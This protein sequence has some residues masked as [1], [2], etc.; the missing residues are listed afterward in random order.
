[1]FLFTGGVHSVITMHTFIYPE[2]GLALLSI[3][4]L[5]PLAKTTEPDDYL[6]QM[7]VGLMLGDGT[8][9]KKYV[10]GSTYF[11]FAQGLVNVDYLQH[12]FDLFKR[13]GYVN[14][15]A[16]SEGKS[17][18][19][20]KTYTWYQFSTRSIPEW[21]DLHAQWYVGKVKVVPANIFD[22]LTPVSLA[23]WHMDDGGWN[24]GGIHLN[25]NS[26]TKDEVEL[27][28]NALRV[29]FNLKCSVQ[30]RNRLYIFA[31]S[32]RAFC[33]IIRPHIHPSMIYKITPL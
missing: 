26:F 16:A 4:P 29:K 32:T 6:N 13:A 25:T 11:K 8:L 5:I 18:I 17:T 2:L 21:N 7:M 19:K 33:D 3:I 9:V 14:M 24:K 22:M 1:M 31:G 20:G 15:D 27:L 10:G 23:Y 30:S 12:V 28:A